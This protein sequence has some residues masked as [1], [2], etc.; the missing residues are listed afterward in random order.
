VPRFSI[1]E[2]F[3][4]DVPFIVSLFERDH[5]AA[6]LNAPTAGMVSAS[7]DDPA[8]ENYIVE[9]DGE[10]AGNFLIANQE[11]LF[12]FKML[13]VATPG[14][15]AGTFALDWGL[16]HAFETCGAHRVFCETRQDNPRT[17]A[18]LERLG[19]TR[20]GQYRDGFRDA[21]SGEFHDLYPYGMLAAEY[22]ARNA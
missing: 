20:E 2:A 10:P 1:R 16:R 14:R 21:K 4:D 17:I 6:I 3:E 19:F 22:R 18:L 11:W 7:L 12:E 8:A 9:A 15:G 13:A 5:V